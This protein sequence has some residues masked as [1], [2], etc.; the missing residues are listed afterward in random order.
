M[1][2]FDDLAVEF[3]ALGV[4]FDGGSSSLDDSVIAGRPPVIL[5]WVP[6]FQRR[7]RP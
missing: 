6:P 7:G 1:A 4:E 3:D 2:L 5:P